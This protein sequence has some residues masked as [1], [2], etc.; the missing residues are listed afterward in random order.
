MNKKRREGNPLSPLPV[1]FFH[2]CIFY[3]LATLVKFPMTRINLVDPGFLR[4]KHLGAEYRELP[5][6]FGAVRKYQSKGSRPS[7]IKIPSTYVLGKGHVTFF[8]NKLRWLVRRQHAL[9]E[10]LIKRGKNPKFRNPEALIA[11]LDKEWL[12]DWEPSLDEIKLNVSRINERGG[13]RPI[14]EK[15]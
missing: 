1:I 12:N 11:G 13:L 8:Y 14:E 6:I 5:R 7:S 3:M 15:K 9:V 10:E 4:D 2:S